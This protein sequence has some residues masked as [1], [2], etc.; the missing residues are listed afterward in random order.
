MNINTILDNYFEHDSSSTRIET[1]DEKSIYSV[2]DKIIRELTKVV[3]IEL[4][5]LQAFGYC[6]YELLDNALTHSEKQ[7]GTILYNYNADKHL[8]KIAIA[9]DGI[10]IYRSLTKNEKYSKL[11]IDEA[12]ALQSCIIDGVTDGKGLGFGLYS[13]SR[14]IGL[15][16][17]EMH[18]HSGSYKLKMVGD[19][20]EI[21]D[22]DFWTGTLVYL[23]LH[24]DKEIDA[25]LVVDNRTDCV[26]EF[27]EQ[28]IDDDLDEL[29]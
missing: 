10:G 5:V 8:L 25:N 14:L 26:S 28:F 7:C 4:S 17:S 18:I 23:Q 3:S 22:S 20:S 1:F 21:V 12:E 2:Y 29:W 13:T 24:T 15:G 9:D 19:F 16:D 6:F 27:N 11:N